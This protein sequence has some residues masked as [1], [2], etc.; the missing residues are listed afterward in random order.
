MITTK[1]L[2]QIKKE[3][4]ASMNASLQSAQSSENSKMVKYFVRVADICRERVI[5][6]DRLI[7]Q[8]KQNEK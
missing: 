2:Q 1:E 6:L 7:C 4:L 5:L 8:S 3:N